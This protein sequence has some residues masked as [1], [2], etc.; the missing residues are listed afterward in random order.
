MANPL[1]T[2][3]AD[4]TALPAP[5]PGDNE[6]QVQCATLLNN[7]QQ[8]LA[9][10]TAQ[11]PLQFTHATSGKG[12]F[13]SGTSF[14]GPAGDPNNASSF[15]TRITLTAPL[16]LLPNA[17]YSLTVHAPIFSQPLNLTPQALPP[18]K[19]APAMGV[20]YIS[21]SSADKSVYVVLTLYGPTAIDF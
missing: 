9:E 17:A 15:Q 13:F 16:V 21:A 2:L 18:M 11:G 19:G 5:V 10:I 7:T 3:F 14:A 20:Y 8:G 1:D 4:A 6:V 12:A